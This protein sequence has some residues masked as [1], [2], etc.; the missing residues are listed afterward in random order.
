MGFGDRIALRVDRAK[1]K[2][3]T[4][5]PRICAEF[6]RSVVDGSELT[7][8]PGQP[9]DTGRLKAS[10]I[11]EFQDENHFVLSTDVPYARIIEDNER[12]AQLR[13]SVGG[14]HSVALSV[15]G[16]GAIVDHVAAQVRGDD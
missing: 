8:A 5:F 6:Q 13:S 9:V 16:F 15:A 11:G 12:G 3:K 14:F 4:A 7:N 10:W 2:A 1:T